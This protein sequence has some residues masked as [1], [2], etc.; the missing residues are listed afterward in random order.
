[1]EAV[2]RSS[3]LALVA[4]VV[5][6]LGASDADA[7]RPA[8]PG[9]FWAGLDA[10][11]TVTTPGEVRAL[12]VAPEG[13]ARIAGGTF[14]MGSSIAAMENALGLCKREV[15]S[16]VCAEDDFREIL[17]SE[18]EEHPVTLSSFD[19]DRCEVTVAQYGRCVAAGHCRPAGFAATDERFARPDLPVTHVAWEDAA[20]FCDW[21]GGRLPTEAEWEYAARGPEGRTFPWGNLYNPHLANHGAMASDHTDATDGFVWLA[22]VGS[23]PGGA[24][25]VGVLDLAGNAAEWVAD[26]LEFDASGRRA[27]YEAKPEVDPRPKGGGGYHVVRGGS[28]E[29]PAVWLRSTSRDTTPMPHPETVGFRCA[30]DIER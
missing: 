5:A 29:D 23:F 27:G 10:P 19:L 15:W 9:S 26:T 18:G 13:R 28:Y 12:R 17:Q 7:K 20:A 2:S 11:T 16:T 22:P 6:C 8:R 24:T 4:G 30:A 21:A 1:M 25:P 14:N 3:K